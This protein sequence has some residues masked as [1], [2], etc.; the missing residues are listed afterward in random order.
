VSQQVFTTL[1][2][3]LVQGRVW[4]DTENL[5]GDGAAVINQAFARHYWPHSSPIGQQIRLPGLVSNAPLI[6]ASPQSDGWRTIVGV[7]GDVPNNGLGEPVLPAVYFPYTTL[8]P[9]YAQFHIRTQAEPLT[10]LPAVR[11]AVA[12]VSSAQQIA[13]GAYD[14]AAGLNDDPQWSRQRLFSILF[15]AF[16]AM[17]LLLALAGLFSVVSWSVSQR[18]SEFG[19]RFALGASRAHI[20]WVATRKAA[21]SLLLGVTLG[22]LADLLLSHWLTAWMATRVSGLVALPLAIS[23]LAVSAAIACWLAARRA[24]QT[25]PTEALRYE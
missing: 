14:L 3:P 24:A 5:R 18:T 2:I 22:A 17:A 8:L 21:V 1:G 6:A 19:V 13:N 16:S 4:D 12:S 15:G 9:P 7:V 23:L 25:S 10:Y 11:A 20:L